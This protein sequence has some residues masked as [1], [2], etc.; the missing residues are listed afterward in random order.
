MIPSSNQKLQ[1]F[2]DCAALTFSPPDHRLRLFLVAPQ[3]GQGDINIGLPI[4]ETP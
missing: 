3:V 4:P 2:L 1:L